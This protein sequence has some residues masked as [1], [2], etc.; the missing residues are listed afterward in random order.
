M[1]VPYT[2]TI[3]FKTKDIEV[4]LIDWKPG[5]KSPVHEHGECLGYFKILRGELFERPFTKKGKQ[6]VEGKTRVYK[7]G[8]YGAEMALGV[9]QV[10]NTTKSTAQSLHVYLPPVKN[11]IV[12][13]T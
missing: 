13:T 7:K 5:D 9:H 3:L 2:R 8:D 12:K 11:K 6:F 1:T 10:G 4:V